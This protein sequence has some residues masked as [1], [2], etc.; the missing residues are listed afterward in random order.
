[1]TIKALLE[2]NNKENET[3]CEINVISESILIRF[4]YNG[5]N[6]F[7][8]IKEDEKVIDILK[9]FASKNN[10]KFDCIYFLYKGDIINQEKY[11]FTF[12]K[13]ASKIDRDSNSV[14]IAVYDM[15][16]LSFNNNSRDSFNINNDN[17]PQIDDNNNMENSDSNFVSERG[18]INGDGPQNSNVLIENL[19][20]RSR[21]SRST[22][23]HSQISQNEEDSRKFY[24][25]FLTILSIQYIFIVLFS[26]LGFYLDFNKYLIEANYAIEVTP[27]IIAIIVMAVIANEVLKKYSK[28]VYLII[29]QVFSALFT[30]YFSY[31]LSKYIESKYIIISLSLILIELVSME[32]YVLLFKNYKI[33]FIALSYSILGLI[34]LIFFSIFWIKELLPI[35]YISIFWLFSIAFLFVNIYI[36]KKI[37]K[38]EEYFYACI[39][40]NYGLFL[41]IAWGLKFIY[42]IIK[43]KYD[44]LDEKP[45]IQLKIYSVFIIQNIITISLAI[46]GFN[47]NWNNSVIE[48][49]DSLKYFS[50]PTL[51]INFIIC[52][53]VL[54]LFPIS[55]ERANIDKSEFLC[56]I[57]LILYMPFM[58]IFSFISSCILESKYILCLL[59]ILLLN[60]ITIDLFIFFC[61]SSNLLGYF[62]S[63]VIMNIAS[64]LFFHSLWLKDERAILYNSIIPLAYLILWTILSYKC[65]EYLIDPEKYNFGL[66]GF[67]YIIFI[68][69]YAAII[70]VIGIGLA[71]S[72]GLVILAF[73]C[74]CMFLAGCAQG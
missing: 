8:Q 62:F 44:K 59:I 19:I 56:Y 24:L 11:N 66:V 57:C 25:Y 2:L 29:Y 36:I 58:I 69:I 34:G 1:M 28:S 50:I 71:I 74:I 39:I 9:R 45:L 13:F 51:I 42:D 53:L 31:L 47:L 12:D 68:V 3:K 70:L 15:D 14:S 20:D 54:Y 52:I 22:S 6:L 55:L 72:V 43:A 21:D 61:N 17:N 41:L 26:W 65:R 63:P 5:D 48:S 18:A 37:C 60:L 7:L 73:Y 32:L 30:I 40:F 33:L 16:P 67:N 27:V 64:V 4:E 23:H 46:L 49:L 10:I 38:L 35:V